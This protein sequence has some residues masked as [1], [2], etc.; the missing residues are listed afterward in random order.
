[1]STEE[2]PGASSLALRQVA[3]PVDLRER[4]WEESVVECVPVVECEEEPAAQA[5]AVTV[6]HSVTH[7]GRHCSVHRRPILP[8]NVPGDLISHLT[9]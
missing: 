2:R 5:H 1:M 6:V 4:G 8:Q 7:Q 9:D 3:W